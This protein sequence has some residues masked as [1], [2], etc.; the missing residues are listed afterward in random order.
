MFSE[1]GVAVVSCTCG[2][3]SSQATISKKAIPTERVSSK[4]FE[5]LE[6]EEAMIKK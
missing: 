3:G 5:S 4:L 2:L 1:T 6:L